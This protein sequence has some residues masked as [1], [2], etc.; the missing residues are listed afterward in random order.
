[1]SVGYL[2]QADDFAP[3]ATVRDI[4]VGGQPDHVWAADATTR[5][6]VEHLL[7]EVDLDARSPRSAAA[8]AAGW[9]WSR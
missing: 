6:V 4:I 5:A 9:R 8:S 2:H 1:M 3:A 7:A